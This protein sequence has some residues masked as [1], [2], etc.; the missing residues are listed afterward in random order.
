MHGCKQGILQ[1]GDGRFGIGQ[2]SPSPGQIEL[3]NQSAPEL[4]LVQLDGFPPGFHVFSRDVQPELQRPDFNI[5]PGDFPLEGDQR[6]PQRLPGSCQI[7][8]RRLHL[9]ANA[10]KYVNLP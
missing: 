3:R 9:P 6:I 7:G 2:G 8:I 10:S 5:V 1:Q 4:C